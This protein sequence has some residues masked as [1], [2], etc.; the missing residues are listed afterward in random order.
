MMAEDTDE[1]GWDDNTDDNNELS[2]LTELSTSQ[3][4]EPFLTQPN[5][6]PDPPYNKAARTPTSS[7]PGKRKLFDSY[8]DHNSSTSNS[9]ILVTPSS[10]RSNRSIGSSRIPPS[11]AELCMTPTPT[12]YRDV[13]SSANMPDMSDLAAEASAIMEQYDVVLPNKARDDLVELLNRHSLKLQ[14]VNKGREVTRQALKKKEDELAKKDGEIRRLQEKITSLQAQ[15][16]MDQSI[17]DSMST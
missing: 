14:G 16:E 6:N 10:T 8:N 15:K 4:T 7:S 2:E 12:K 13:I 9:S 5:W 17:I 1:F 11:S 3:S